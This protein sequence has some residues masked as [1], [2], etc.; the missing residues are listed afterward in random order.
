MMIELREL[1]GS[2]ATIESCDQE[3]IHTPN[4]IQAH[5]AVLVAD[6]NSLRIT[7]CSANLEQFLARTPEW[8]IGR[9]LQDVIG[10]AAIPTIGPELAESASSI[11]NV[12]TLPGGSGR[13]LNT[14]AHQTGQH[15]FIDLHPATDDN[16][17]SPLPRVHEVLETLM[18]AKTRG[19]LCDLAVEALRAT[20]GFDRVM[21]YRFG[22]EGEGKVISEAKLESLEPFWGMTYPADDIPSQARALYVRN[23]VCAIADSSYI[24]V[25]L[26]VDPAFDD[27][28]PIDMTFSSLRGISPIHCEYMRNMNVAASLAISIVHRGSLWG[29]LVCHHNTPRIVT[30]ELRSV[31]NLLGQV[32]S[33]LIGSLGE[34]EAYADRLARQSVMQSIC[35]AI[36]DDQPIL[37]GLTQDPS[38]LLGLVD[39]GG[40]VVR[41]SGEE[42]CFG[43]LPPPAARS[44]LLAELHRLANRKIFAIDELGHLYPALEGCAETASGALFLPFGAKRD[45]AIVWFRPELKRNIV[46]G[47]DPSKHHGVD[48]VT[49]RLT[50]RASFAAWNQEISGRSLPWTDV[51]LALAADLRRAIENETASRANASAILAKLAY[52]D[53]LTGLPNRRRLEDW[54]LGP[55]TAARGEENPGLLFIGFDCF[56]AINDSMGHA[57]GDKLL[58]EAASRLL[59]TTGAH[60]LVARLGGDEF[61]VV[62]FGLDAAGVAVLAETIRGALELPF[63]INGI[64]TKASAS[65]GIA[66]TDEIGSLDIVLAADMA[67]YAAK[68]LGGNRVATFEQSFHDNALRTFELDQDL[69]HAINETEQFILVYQPLFDIRSPDPKLLG[70]EALLRWWH[71][72]LGWVA[73]ETFIP[74]AEKSGVIVRLGDWIILSAVRQAKVMSAANPEIPLLMTINISVLQ[75]AE[76]GFC[77]RLAAILSDVKV[78]ASTICLE[79]TESMFS[80]KAIADVL[81]EVRAM[82]VRIA[83]DDFGTGFSSLSYLRR[84]PADIVKL[85]RGFLDNH[86]DDTEDLGFVSAVVTLVHAAGMTV[87][88]EGVETTDQYVTARMAGADMVQGFMFNRPLVASDAMKLVRNGPMVAPP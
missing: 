55:A 60:H 4:V 42:Y 27:G 20:S 34:A 41:L 32:L 31:A 2:T 49:S 73:P 38:A 70:F 48:P 75:L 33:L 7:H 35:D 13:M 63:V 23:R 37:N 28:V 86:K 30:P 67:M 3:L 66:M 51:D 19:E 36:G 74:I 65:I 12:L 69:R 80:D 11:G 44:E 50:P 64:S 24:P 54:L 79:V 77:E 16:E 5:G 6:I 21:A 81:R 88:Q 52:F 71:P 57:A 53:P 9:E 62:T 84:L 83:I 82:G 47:G 10:T 25:P 18:S 22:P 85:D 1:A 68:Q 72:R 17:G 59:A 29:M 14:L 39:A 76:Q 45:D 87:V 8:A 15:L 46:W 40:V 78:P 43:A 58:V 26:L 61:V 56:K